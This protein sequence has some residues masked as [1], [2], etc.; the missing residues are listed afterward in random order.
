MQQIKNSHTVYVRRGIG[1]E[2]TP[3]EYK[4]YRHELKIFHKWFAENV[5]SADLMLIKLAKAMFQAASWPTTITTGRYMYP[6]GDNIHHV[7]LVD[8]SAS[9]G[10]NV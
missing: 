1:K 9:E 4:T 10:N 2:V 6:L 5:F 8:E 7:A 3:E